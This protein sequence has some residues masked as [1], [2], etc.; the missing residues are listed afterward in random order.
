MSWRFREIGIVCSGQI[1]A[2][3]LVLRERMCHANRRGLT[4]GRP[5]R[6][7]NGSRAMTP[8]AE[9]D[10][11]ALGLDDS[12]LKGIDT[13]G[14]LNDMR[15]LISIHADTAG[16]DRCYGWTA[17]VSG[18]KRMSRIRKQS[19]LSVPS[20]VWSACNHTIAKSPLI[21]ARHRP[22]FPAEPPSPS[23]PRSQMRTWCRPSHGRSLVIEAAT[24][25]IRV[26]STCIHA[27]DRHRLVDYSSF[28]HLSATSPMYGS[29][30]RPSP[31]CASFQAL[32]LVYS[33]TPTEARMK[34]ILRKDGRGMRRLNRS[35]RPSKGVVS[36]ADWY[37]TSVISCWSSGTPA[38]WV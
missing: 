35:K 37:A 19:G 23:Q 33:V 12:A 29:Q 21:V 28:T 17:R 20:G 4:T 14:R 25:G 2:D 24:P 3:P 38:E 5:P 10:E 36:N 22:A 1:W 26:Q 7:H 30:Y 8:T 18:R 9:T 11:C 16:P 27:R 6:I 15:S 31:S 32:K 13:E 34:M